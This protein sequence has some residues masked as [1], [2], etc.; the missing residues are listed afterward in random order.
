MKILSPQ[1]QGLSLWRAKYAKAFYKDK[2]Y[3]DS[4]RQVQTPSRT[5][6]ACKEEFG[7]PAGLGCLEPYTLWRKGSA[8]A[9]ETHMQIVCE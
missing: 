1:S 3:T 9:L 2:Y 5:C 8:R 6:N 7:P 4:E